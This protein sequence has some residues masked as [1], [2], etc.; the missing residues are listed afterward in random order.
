[1]RLWMLFIAWTK[2]I[3]SWALLYAGFPHG[4]VR[5]AHDHLPGRT[6]LLRILAEQGLYD[7]RGVQ[8]RDPHRRGHFED[9]R[10]RRRRPVRR[11]HKT[12]QG[13]DPASLPG[14]FLCL[15]CNHP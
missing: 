7:R 13:G 3:W 6:A 8:Q 14:L 11:D 4:A 12:R 10:G 2:A 5:G 15:Y 1:M 9:R